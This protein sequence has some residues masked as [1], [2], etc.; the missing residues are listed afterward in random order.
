MAVTYEPLE[1]GVLNVRS[2]AVCAVAYSLCRL[3]CASNYEYGGGGNLS[4]KFNVITSINAGK[5]VYKH[6]TNDY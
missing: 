3:V 6:A 5:C 1:L 2:K 4:G